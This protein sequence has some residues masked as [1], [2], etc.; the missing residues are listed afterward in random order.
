MAAPIDQCVEHPRGLLSGKMILKLAQEARGWRAVPR[1]LVEHA[2]DMGLARWR[3][4]G[5][6]W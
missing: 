1:P 5:H 2:A 3:K 4:S 6:D